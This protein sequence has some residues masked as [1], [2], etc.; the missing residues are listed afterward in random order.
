MI[1]AA[2]ALVDQ[3]GD[4]ICSCWTTGDPSSWLLP[5]VLLPLS[6]HQH[7]ALQILG[8]EKQLSSCKRVQKKKK[9]VLCPAIAPY[10]LCKSFSC[11]EL[12]PHPLPA[13]TPTLPLGCD[14]QPCRQIQSGLKGQVCS[15]WP[16]KEGRAGGHRF[17]RCW[18][19]PGADF[20]VG[21]VLAPAALLGVT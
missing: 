19:T 4:G 5:D 21:K 7:L 3:A 13:Q 10:P 8:V 15:G 18:L 6:S 17:L 11:A 14:S 12:C 1:R 2:P 20:W 9:R 16:C